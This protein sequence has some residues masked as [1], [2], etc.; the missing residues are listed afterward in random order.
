MDDE[1]F[2]A[3]AKVLGKITGLSQDAMKDIWTEVKA[4]S[5]ALAACAGPHQFE[6]E[7][8][9]LGSKYRCA[10]CGGKISG[11]DFHWYNAGVAHG[12]L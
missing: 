11:S 10:L 6:R 5:D 1:V 3:A 12:R 9:A 4:N 7:G 2:G 8:E